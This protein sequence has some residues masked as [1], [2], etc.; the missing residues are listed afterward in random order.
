MS[1]SGRLGTALFML[2][3]LPCIMVLS[4]GISGPLAPVISQAN[5]IC[6]LIVGLTHYVSKSRLAR[7]AGAGAVH[8][9]P[10]LG[11]A[12]ALIGLSFGLL[13]GIASWIGQVPEPGASPSLFLQALA[14]GAIFVVAAVSQALAALVSQGPVGIF[15]HVRSS[16]DAQ[17]VSL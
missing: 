4:T 5:L 7:Q 11:A 17:E 10:S 3:F 8:S 2:I 12:F 16:D 1:H 13:V 6:A 15:G 14:I 9:N